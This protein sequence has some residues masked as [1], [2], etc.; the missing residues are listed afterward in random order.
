MKSMQ[1]SS[2]DKGHGYPATDLVILAG[3]EAKRM[4]G[5]N[6][7]LQTFDHQIQLLKIYQQLKHQ[8]NQVWINSHRDYSTY[9]RLVPQ[10][11]CFKDDEAG[12]LGPM[13]GMKSAWS[14]VQSDYVLFIP[15][16]VTHIPEDVISNLHALLAQSDACEVAILEIN[17]CA[18]YPF[19]L[20]KRSALPKLRQN[21]DKNQRSLKRCFVDMHY[22]TALIK[23]D[24]LFFHSI[25]SL[26]ELQ[27]YK[28]LEAIT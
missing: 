20:M 8:V 21:L 24:A 26:D 10:V 5:L 19:C 25:N 4:N 13:M 2:K 15:C 28:Q 16:D 14:H 27:Q 9:Q 7:L 3:G 11:K 6:K 23:D 1:L 12:F 17:E 22:K 18:L